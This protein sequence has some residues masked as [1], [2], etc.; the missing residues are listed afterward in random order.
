MALSPAYL[1]R[2]MGSEK[3]KELSRHVEAFLH[4]AAAEMGAELSTA[5]ETVEDLLLEGCRSRGQEDD[6]GV[7]KS[8][9]KDREG[10]QLVGDSLD[11]IAQG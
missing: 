4:S 1:I 2:A 10:Q 6:S 5:R 3:R 9:N 8:D 7:E 11:E